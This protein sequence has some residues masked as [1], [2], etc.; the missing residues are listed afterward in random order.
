MSSDSGEQPE[1]GRQLPSGTGSPAVRRKAPSMVVV[2]SEYHEAVP[3]SVAPAQPPGFMPSSA[4]S[5]L[6][7]HLQSLH[8]RRSR[9]RSGLQ[10]RPQLFWNRVH[11]RRPPR[12]LSGHPS[13]RPRSRL[14]SKA[15]CRGSSPP[16]RWVEHW[17]LGNHSCSQCTLDAGQVSAEQ[18][19]APGRAEISAD[20]AAGRHS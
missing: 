4:Y 11:T 2:M 13:R 1:H 17:T 19:S 10:W 6:S 20:R 9:G 12:S 3:V 15:C 5:M 7:S 16:A 14:A 18:I 8:H